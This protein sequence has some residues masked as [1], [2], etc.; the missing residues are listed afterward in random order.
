MHT[1]FIDPRTMVCSTCN[2]T[3]EAIALGRDK[4]ATWE[5]VDAAYKKG[6]A[7][8]WKSSFRNFRRTRR[9]KLIS[10]GAYLQIRQMRK[11]VGLDG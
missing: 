3:A 2:L 9:R 7:D 6:W 8:G 4:P 11:D 10:V 1:H 5:D